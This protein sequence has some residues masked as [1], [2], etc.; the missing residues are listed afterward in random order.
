MPRP[1]ALAN[2]SPV[3]REAW[4]TLVRLRGRELLDFESYKA[5]LAAL[6]DTGARRPEQASA[7]DDRDPDFTPACWTVS[8]AALGRSGLYRLWF[9]GPNHR[10]V[11]IHVTKDGLAQLGRAIDEMLGTKRAERPAA[12]VPPEAE[13]DGLGSTS[14]PIAEADLSDRLHR[15]LAKVTERRLLAEVALAAAVFAVTLTFGLASLINRDWPGAIT[16]AVATLILA[17]VYWRAVSAGR[18]T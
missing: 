11:R 5:L 7:S 16:A 9:Q 13:P 10:S 1:D 12:A 3:Q 14:R 15:S 4:D 8:S 18:R 17:G 2:L 6:I